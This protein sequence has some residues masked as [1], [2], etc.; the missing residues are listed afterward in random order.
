MRLGRRIPPIIKK[1]CNLSRS[2][3]PRRLLLFCAIASNL[4]CAVTRPHD[5]DLLTAPRQVF[6]VRHTERESEGE[7]PPLVAAGEARAQALAETLR[8]A[9]ITRIITTQW[10]RTRDTAQPLAKLLRLIAAGDSGAG[11]KGTGECRR[12][13]GGGAPLQGRDGAHSR[14]YYSHRRYRRSRRTESADDLRQRVFRPVLVRAVCR[15]SGFNSSPLRRCRRYF[16]ALP[17]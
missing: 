11:R 4:G 10:R 1:L 14:A 2:V 13:C 3:I 5:G 12:S 7:D 9:G 15:R 6:L 16:A 8:D 17:D